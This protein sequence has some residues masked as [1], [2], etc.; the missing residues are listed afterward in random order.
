MHCSYVH[1]DLNSSGVL[2]LCTLAGYGKNM[3]TGQFQL[4]PVGL[5]QDTKKSAQ[6]TPT[7]GQDEANDKANDVI[8]LDK[9]NIVLLGPTGCG[10]CLCVCVWG[11]GGGGGLYWVGCIYKNSC[12]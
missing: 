10:K 5:G 4:L 6:A 2:Y 12:Q 3:L 11:G 7:S 1:Q 8:K 9:S